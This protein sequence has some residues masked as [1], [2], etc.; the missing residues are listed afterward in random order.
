MLLGERH[1]SNMLSTRSERFDHTILWSYD[2]I[3]T[4][5]SE[6]SPRRKEEKKKQKREKE[7]LRSRL[8]RSRWLIPNAIARPA[9][10]RSAECRR[11]NHVWAARA[12]GRE[13]DLDYRVIT[14]ED[15]C[16]ECLT[17]AGV[18]D[19]SPIL[20]IETLTLE[21]VIRSKKKQRHDNS[22]LF[23]L[24][25][26]AVR[27]FRRGFNGKTHLWVK[28]I[29]YETY[30]N[31]ILYTSRLEMRTKSRRQAE[32]SVTSFLFYICDL[33]LA[34]TNFKWRTWKSR[35]FQVCQGGPGSWEHDRPE[36]ISKWTTSI[37]DDRRQQKR[38]S[39]RFVFSAGNG[40]KSVSGSYVSLL[41]ADE[42]VVGWSTPEFHDRFGDRTRTRAPLP[43]VVHSQRRSPPRAFTA[44]F[45][46]VRTCDAV[47]RDCWSPSC[48][49]VAMRYRDD[50][51]GFVDWQRR[52]RRVVVLC[53][54]C[55]RVGSLYKRPVRPVW[56]VG[57]GGW[58]RGIYQQPWLAR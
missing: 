42:L 13:T 35:L 8:H 5:R 22:D 47:Q 28:G 7:R 17:D 44:S 34:N 1:R 53:D 40:L 37:E 16:S 27:L 3:H 18:P 26:C 2:M 41:V 48:S 49:Q 51:T 55:S 23:I 38:Y 10:R 50:S 24:E 6:L 19:A 21:C 11:E 43:V 57:S 30:N 15:G 52:L 45:T 20:L 4:R 39:L 29:I 31:P 58:Q 14:N 36:S 33:R 9:M 46:H 54:Q 12:S 56:P 32:C 25:H